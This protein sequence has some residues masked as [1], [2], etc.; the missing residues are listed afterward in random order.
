MIIESHSAMLQK[1]EGQLQLSPKM[2]QLWQ[3]LLMDTCPF[4]YILFFTKNLN[5]QCSKL[6][7]TNVF[8]CF[9]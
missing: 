7:V 2:C 6:F 8:I 4:S 3:M 1:T 5:A 9:V